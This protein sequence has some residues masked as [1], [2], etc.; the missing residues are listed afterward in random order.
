MS[1]IKEKID[2]AP[3]ISFTTDAW[4]SKDQSH[5]LL[6]LTAHFINEEFVPSF[7]VLS[8]SSISGRHTAENL[9]GILNESLETFA[10]GPDRIHVVL[11]DAAANMKRMTNLM[12]VSS[13]DC[14][15]HKLQL[16]YF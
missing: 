2:T 12:S 6:S 1:K 11:R 3:F 8:A 9:M 7:F 5:Q 16:V 4:S 15:A 13:M 10:I 14:F